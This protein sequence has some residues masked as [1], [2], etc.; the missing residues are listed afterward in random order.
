[1]SLTFQKRSGLSALLAALTL[2]VGVAAAPASAQTTQSGLVNVVVANNTVQVP[3]GVAANVCGVQAAVL[4]A[5]LFQNQVV[6]CTAVANATAT[7]AAR[8]GGGGGA[9]QSGLV[10]IAI[11]NNTIQVPVAVAA[12][13]CG[14]QA[15]VLAAG[16]I[17]N[18]AVT[19]NAR[20]NATANA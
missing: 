11:V 16:V 12:N 8:G 4:A 7:R 19:C 15:A 2:A 17:Q 20:G 9:N 6:D 1:M 3:I 13:I 5:N 14:V 10:N 18:Q